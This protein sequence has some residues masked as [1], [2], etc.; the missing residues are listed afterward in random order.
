MESTDH[1]G[2]FS[3]LAIAA[4][5]T[6]TDILYPASVFLL[7][8]VLV[9]VLITATPK[10]ASVLFLWR[11]LLTVAKSTIGWPIVW[12]GL[13]R[14]QSGIEGA[15]DLEGDGGGQGTSPF[16]LLLLLVAVF[17]G[18]D[19]EGG[20][21]S[22]AVWDGSWRGG[23]GGKG[24]VGRVV[25]GLYDVICRGD[26]LPAVLVGGWRGSDEALVIEEA[27]KGEIL[28]LDWWERRRERQRQTSIGGLAAL[29]LK[30]FLIAVTHRV[31]IQAVQHTCYI[32]ITGPLNQC[33]PH[34]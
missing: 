8:L 25:G 10:E 20:R 5:V 9:L 3:S 16:D 34:M 7:V 11:I 26:D 17:V 28:G 23:T 30:S 33:L 29:G 31:S 22:C 6:V 2:E 12:T 15:K 24:G 13:W 21:G 4:S 27:G 32:I 1:S 14:R 19:A 18:D